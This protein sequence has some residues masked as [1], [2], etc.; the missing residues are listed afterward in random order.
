MRQIGILEKLSF[1]ISCG[2]MPPDPTLTRAFGAQSYYC[3]TNNC[4]RRVCYIVSFV[5]IWQFADLLLKR[6]GGVRGVICK[7]PL[8]FWYVDHLTV[9]KGKNRPGSSENKK[10]EKG[11]LPAACYKLSLYPLV[12]QLKVLIYNPF[13][14]A[15]GEVEEREHQRFQP[16]RFSRKP[17]VFRDRFHPPVFCFLEKE[18]NLLYLFSEIEQKFS[19][20]RQFV[21]AAKET[22][23]CKNSRQVTFVAD[24]TNDQN[25]SQWSRKFVLLS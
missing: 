23:N 17:P 7:Y 19:F 15:E 11:N 9:D 18:S 3:R 4:F 21:E 14:R 8:S 16:P 22:W 12:L 1:K 20:I 25:W 24:F 5:P 2:S 6:L 13:K 10:P